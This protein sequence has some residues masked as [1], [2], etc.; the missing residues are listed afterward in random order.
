MV[1]KRSSTVVRRKQI[2]SAAGKLIVKYGSE[3]VTVRRIADEIGTSESAIYRHFKSKSDILSLLVDD[4]K[5]TLISEIALKPGETLSSLITLENFLSSHVDKI[6]QRKGTSFQVIAEIVSFG[7]KKLNKKIY[8][9]V[10]EYIKTIRNLF[11]GGVKAGFL[12]QDID[13]DTASS[14]FFS[15]IQGLVTRWALSHYSFDMKL[16]YFASW[17]VFRKTIGTH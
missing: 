3:H 13:L 10:N 8:D 5:E 4:I 6:I 15:M 16:S 17:D 9:V 11:A 7:D 1:Q 2:I 12:N 14:L